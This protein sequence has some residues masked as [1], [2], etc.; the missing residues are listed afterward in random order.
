MWKSVFW[1]HK[2]L[3][4]IPSEANCVVRTQ[5]GVARAKRGIQFMTAWRQKIDFFTNF[6]QPQW[7]Y[8]TVTHV[9]LCHRNRIVKFCHF[10]GNLAIWRVFSVIS[11]VFR[12][13]FYIVIIYL[14]FVDIKVKH[15]L[16]LP[17]L[18]IIFTKSVKFGF[19]WKHLT[20]YG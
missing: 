2:V 15:L 20:V 19:F 1:P 10:H 4:L 8:Y 18:Y 3:N 7:V 6:W 13:F 5:W 17:E 12:L 16:F 11:R 9:A 14:S